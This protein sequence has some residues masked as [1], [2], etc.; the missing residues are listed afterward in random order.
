M[1][2]NV[3]A[4]L[5]IDFDHRQAAH[6]ESGVCANLLRHY[7]LDISEAMAF[8]I[9]SGL[10]FAYLPFIR[11]NGLPLTTYRCEV[12]GIVKRV[13]RRLGCR[14]RWQKF[15]DPHK[16]M[17]ALDEMLA[18]GVPVACRTGGYWLPYFPPAFRFHFNMHN[19]VVC[20]KSADQYTISDPV[21]P[22]LEHCSRKDLGKARFA[23][24]AL[25][26]KGAMYYVESAPGTVDLAIPARQ[27]IREVCRRMLST[28]VPLIGIRG[29]RYLARQVRQWP[30]KLGE[31]R[32][33]LYVGQLIRMQEELGTGGAGF[34]FMFAAFLQEAAELL[35]LPRL[36]DLSHTMTAVGDHWR[37]FAVIGGRICK[38][39]ASADDNYDAMADLL[40][41]CA[42]G[43]A[44]VYRELLQRIKG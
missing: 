43:E 28:P 24:G 40:Q 41:V 26:P 44:A 15:R 3:S 34:R 23:K 2:D 21:F 12:G 4:T 37:K 16:A 33:I 18:Q 8:G 27:G 14:V 32:A 22:D 31:E 30:R 42:D 11:V 17:D 9:G 39:R 25:A 38:G 19:L 35:A 1:T 29:I 36:M 5:H 6:C 20:G 10:F 13:T 7:G